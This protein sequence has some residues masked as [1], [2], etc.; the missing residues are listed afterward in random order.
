MKAVC[1]PEGVDGTTSHLGTTFLICWT[2]R[3]PN[4]KK[5]YCTWIT[6][7]QLLW[8]IFMLLHMYNYTHWPFL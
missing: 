8:L 4:L 3:K 6:L 5:F 2:V 1:A 7:L